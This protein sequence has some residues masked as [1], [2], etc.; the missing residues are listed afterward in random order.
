MDLGLGLNL[1]TAAKVGIPAGSAILGYLERRKIKASIEKMKASQKESKVRRKTE[2]QLSD[3]KKKEIRELV[4]AFTGGVGEMT[5]ELV[6]LKNV[7]NKTP[8]QTSDDQ[9]ID[10]D[11]DDEE[12]AE[13]PSRDSSKCPRCG[14]HVE[15]EYRSC[16]GC[17]ARIKQECP[18]CHELLPASF[19]SCPKC[20]TTFSKLW[21][22]MA[23]LRDG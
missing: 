9:S 7:A 12:D 14:S 3:T 22:P 5:S 17:A 16:P 13:S 19:K 11:P 1:E 6:D 8:R 2:K 21:D 15:K 18:G 20:G 23:D 4:L 10:D